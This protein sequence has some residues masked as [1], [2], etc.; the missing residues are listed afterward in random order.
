[1]MM[2]VSIF[3]PL[4]PNSN[5]GQ[6]MNLIRR[7]GPISRADIAKLTGLT[8]PTVTNITNRL[9]GAD[10]IVEYRM[11]DSNGGRPPL[12]LKI[13]EKIAQVIIV[14]LDS[15]EMT[16][17][18][19][20]P[21]HQI[22]HRGV[23]KIKE[24]KEEDIL[25]RLLDL[26]EVCR[27]SATSPVPA[28]GVVVRGP[29]TLQEGISVFAPNIGWRNVPLK[30]IVEQRF[31]LPAFIENDSRALTVGEY[32]YGL[33]KD[34]GSM[35]LLQV[36]HGIGSGIMLNGML[37]RGKNNSAGEVGHT[38]IDIGGPKC[39]CGNYGCLEALASEK[40]LLDS[41]V[42]A[43]KEGQPS[44]V[45]QFVNG[46]LSQV[47]PGDIY[48]AADAGDS[49]SIRMLGRVA[50]YLGIGIA[51]LINIFNPEVVV[52]SGGIATA[53]NY[54]EATI[55]QTVGD[56][57]FESCSVVL[58]IRFSTMI[59]G[60]ILKGAADMIFTKITEPVWTHRK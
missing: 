27:R 26:I 22:H 49:L 25:E 41:V 35:V 53:R 60:N 45:S 58:D 38:T 39:S 56:R 50:R 28:I 16:G 20:D 1:M 24:A 55:R 52:I 48:R 5:D 36:S 34:V 10:L 51:N 21:E 18:L 54:V 8:P 31:Q 37:Y 23:I 4:S 33:A 19:V 7:L 17:Y 9:L 57:S 32:Y 46:E 12:L 30:S 40:A 44:L 3:D 15:T 13:N 47:T 59:N 43:M 29:V 11:G 6:V 2:H 42:K 14:H